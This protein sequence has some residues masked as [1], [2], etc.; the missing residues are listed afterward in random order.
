M[1]GD[2]R[3]TEN[4]KLKL[5]LSSTQHS[6]M[7]FSFTFDDD[8]VFF[9]SLH[10]YVKRSF[11]I[12]LS[13]HYYDVVP[14]VM[15]HIRKFQKHNCKLWSTSFHICCAEFFFPKSRWKIEKAKKTLLMLLKLALH[16]YDIHIIT[17]YMF[18]LYSNQISDFFLFPSNSCD[19][20][21]WICVEACDKKQCVHF[22]LP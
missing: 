3:K 5:A 6:P 20:L 4:Q 13:S 9:F 22:H 21:Q 8:L 18:V 1:D 12:F 19:N 17:K 15:M 14:T 2:L 10:A 7:S 16:F 11:R